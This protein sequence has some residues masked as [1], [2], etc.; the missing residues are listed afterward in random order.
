MK[1]YQSEISPDSIVISYRVRLAR[2][3]ENFPFPPKLDWQGT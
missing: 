1:W 2:N 3:I